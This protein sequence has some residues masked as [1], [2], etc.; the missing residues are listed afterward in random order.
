MATQNY[1][2]YYIP[3][4]AVQYNNYVSSQTIGPL[5]SAQTPNVSGVKN[6]GVL[7]GVHPNPPQFYPADNA[8]EF[9]QARFQYANTA[10]SVKQQMI[11]RAKV[12]ATAHPYRFSSLV[13]RQQ[14]P[15]SGHTNYIQPPASSLYTSIKKSQAVGKSSYKQGLPAVAPLSY[16]SYNTNDVRTSL[17]RIRGGGCV[18][19]A[20]CR[21]SRTCTNGAICNIGAASGQG[22]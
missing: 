13:T 21:A 6:L 7:N 2:S 22:Y 11:A 15:V 16:K 20:K 3:P 5:N 17:R 10:T 4:S 14:F 12:L 8:S 19:P 9:A 1:A 18:V